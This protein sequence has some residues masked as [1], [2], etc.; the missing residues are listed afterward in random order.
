MLTAERLLTTYFSHFF[1]VQLT[2]KSVSPNNI[3][4]V[5]VSF[6]ETASAEA[7]TKTITVTTTLTNCPSSAAVAGQC[8]TI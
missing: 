2:S 4:F 1:T 6:A 3:S 8:I 5:V 7:M